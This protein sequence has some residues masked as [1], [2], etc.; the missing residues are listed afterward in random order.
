MLFNDALGLRQIHHTTPAYRGGLWVMSQPGI[1][2]WLKKLEIDDTA[3]GFIDSFEVRKHSEYRWPGTATAFNEIKHLLPNHYL[4]LASGECRRYWPEAPIE[5]RGLDTGIE[6]A[7]E[8][9]RGLM[10]AASRRCD[11]VLGMT[12]GYDSRIVLAAS[13]QIRRELSAVTVRQGRMPDDHQDIVVSAR[14]L[15]RVGMPHDII[16]ALPYMS[17]AFSKTYKENVFMAHDHYGPDAEALLD[18]YRR[19]KMAVTGAGAEV[20]REPFRK[21]IAGL[22][23]VGERTLQEFAGS[24]PVQNADREYVAGTAV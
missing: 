12:A 23:D 19:K 21:R 9:L 2:A 24:Y 5:P 17:A 22:P 8:L 6:Q 15:A 20:A 14:L 11:L 16:K 1:L 13:T 18:F 4:D 7:I 3:L 10:T